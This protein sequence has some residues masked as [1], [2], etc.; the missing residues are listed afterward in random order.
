[1]TS[2]ETNVIIGGTKYLS[3]NNSYLTIGNTGIYG[4]NQPSG[5]IFSI[6]SN[7]IGT[8]NPNGVDIISQ[9]NMNGNAII[10]CPTSF[11]GPT[12]TSFTGPTGASFTG[13]TGA[14][15]TGPTGASFTGP[16]GASFTGPTGSFPNPY[17]SQIVLSNTSASQSST[18]GALQVA[19]GIY[20]G[21][22]GTFAGQLNIT[23]TT[24][25]IGYN[26]GALIVNG[27]VGIGG[28]VFTNGNL[29][30]TTGN[31]NITGNCNANN[32][33][34]SSSIGTGS[35]VCSGGGSFAKTCYFG[36]AN[37]FTQ[38]P[39]IIYY[40]SG[41]SQTLVSGTD[42]PISTTLTTLNSQTSPVTTSTATLNGIASTIYN[43]QYAGIYLITWQYQWCSS[44]SG[45]GSSTNYQTVNWIRQNATQSTPTNPNTTNNTIRYGETQQFMG[46]N[47]INSKAV[48]TALVSCA[49]NDIISI[50][51]YQNTGTNTMYLQSNAPTAT[52]PI[53]MLSFHKLT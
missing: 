21:S 44:A 50:W 42:S 27:G 3:A 5:Y 29:N 16:T 23:N 7:G 49:V 39:T 22:T 15:F 12:G 36:G 48:C 53:S 14:S 33:T 46:N 32:T 6:N 20:M 28:N 24:A 26:S 18:S 2:Q 43:I 11:T 31:I 8:T 13:P 30:L 10:N 38:Q 47:G 37:Y 41:N 35:L 25:S 1:M 52:N 9:L 17:P 51:A 45:G 40:F 4:Y 19:G 34:A